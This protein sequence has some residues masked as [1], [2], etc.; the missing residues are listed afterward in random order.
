MCMKYNTHKIN[1]PACGAGIN[2]TINISVKKTMFCPYCGTQ[3]AIDDGEQVVTHNININNQ[4][5]N[6]TDIEKEKLKTVQKA[7]LLEAI[8]GT[9]VCMMIF[10]CAFYYL[11]NEKKL[12][13]IQEKQAIEAGQIKVGIS[14][15]E[16]EGKNYQVVRKQLEGIGF[17][18]ITEVDLDDV[19][20]NS[21]KEN[22]VESVIIDGDDFFSALDYFDPDANIVISY[23]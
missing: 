16:M 2:T 8:F 10:P 5:T 13:A 15:S 22:T 14:S 17:T 18:N 19:K 11:Y 21:R 12:N 6:N 1:C 7:N 23:H 3:F 20:D 9:L 4:Y